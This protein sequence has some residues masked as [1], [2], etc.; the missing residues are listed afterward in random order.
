MREFEELSK[1]AILATACEL[2][3][4]NNGVEDVGCA[5]ESRKGENLA[6]EDE[7]EEVRARIGRR[8]A[9]ANRKGSLK[10]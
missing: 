9:K 5:A 10:P 1:E 6:V 8:G 4:A 7:A 2:S 3:A